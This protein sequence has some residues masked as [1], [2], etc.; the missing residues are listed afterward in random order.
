MRFSAEDRSARI[1]F[2]VVD[3]MLTA[4]AFAAA[5][6]TRSWLHFLPHNFSIPR[7][8]K[9]LMLSFWV[10]AW[11]CCGYWLGIYQK[12]KPGGRARIARDAA[13]QAGYAAIAVVIFEYALRLDISR[14]FLI[15]TVLYSG[16]VI[17]I[18]RL[19]APRWLGLFL[20][21][22][23]TV[24]NLLIGGTGPRALREAK[25]IENSLHE[26]VR[27]CGFVDV[28]PRNGSERLD[29]PS[30]IF[31]LD[32]LPEVFR[33]QAID[34]IVFVVQDQQI[35]LLQDIFLLCEEHG[36]C[37]RLA[38]DF[39]PQVKTEVRLERLGTTPLLTFD[40]AP[41]DAFRMLVKRATDVLL[42]AIGLLLA[43][44][45]MLAATIA[46]RLTSPG[47]V[48]F[49]QQR[50]GLNGHQF[51]CYK[52]RSMVADADQ[53]RAEVM[54]LSSR[55]TAPKIPNDPRLTPVGRL[56]RKFSIDELPQLIN[57]IQGEMSL[58]GPRPAIPSEVAQYKNWQHRRLRMRPGLTCLW[59]VNGRDE[60]DF[61]TWM[62]M[63]LQ[64]IENWS[65]GLDWQIILKTIPTVLSGKGAS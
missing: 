10:A 34:E 8:E 39:F 16:A 43:S 30:P 42:A 41:D 55:E 53:R 15:V 60:I 59:A 58:V 32:Q 3:A 61:E 25:Q 31:S 23:D 47:P 52:F 65:L 2:T 36:V 22:Y 18:S 37:T 40:A 33:S 63:D 6:I 46:I 4:L 50:C 54:H 9:A 62:K 5:Y 27:I 12:T 49:R 17:L 56:L 1:V 28:P 45:I 13:A 7:T 21:D 26:R 57:V 51:V 44:P 20:N 38:V 11:I 29:L 48:I 14:I 24:R 64:Y 35:A 19:Y